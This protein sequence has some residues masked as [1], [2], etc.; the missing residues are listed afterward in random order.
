MEIAKS[1]IERAIAYLDEAAKLYDALARQSVIVD[2]HRSSLLRLCQLLPRFGAG[3]ARCRA[4][5]II[6]LSRK[7][8]SKLSRL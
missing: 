1:D 7:L 4:H 3:K 5:M 2:G 8:K 6:Q